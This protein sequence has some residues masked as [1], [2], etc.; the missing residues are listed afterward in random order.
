MPLLRFDSHQ[1]LLLVQRRDATLDRF[2]T[3]PLAPDAAAS[4][5]PPRAAARAAAA[6]AAIVILAVAVRPVLAESH[7]EEPRQR[8]GIHHAANKEA[9]SSIV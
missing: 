5:A 4:G 8:D 7:L 3:E 2:E 1:L 6:A 9:V